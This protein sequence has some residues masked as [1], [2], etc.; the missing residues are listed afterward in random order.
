MADAEKLWSRARSAYELYPERFTPEKVLAVSEKTLE[1]FV[2]RLG[3]RFGPSAAK[4]WKR[5]PQVL[6]ERYG[7]DKKATSRFP[8][9]TRSQTCKLLYPRHGRDGAIQG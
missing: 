4:T 2:R 1:V 3:A 6:M 5:I 7:G 8:L 9:L